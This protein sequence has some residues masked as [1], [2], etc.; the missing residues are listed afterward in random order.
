MAVSVNVP[1]RRA[2]RRLRSNRRQEGIELLIAIVALMWVIEVIY[3]L[4]GNALD[5]DGIHPRNVDRIWGIVTAPFLHVSFA[6][7]I[8]N[9]IPLLFM[10]LIIGLRGAARLTLVT[11][12]VIVIGGLGTWL[13]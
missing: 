11:A 3:S 1:D 9:T 7:L 12:I 6:H 2:P 13:I 4:D 10:G 8:S 5:A